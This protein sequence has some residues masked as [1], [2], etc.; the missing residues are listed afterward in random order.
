MKSDALGV[1]QAIPNHFSN[2]TFS[3]LEFK[4]IVT[5]QESSKI[6]SFFCATAEKRKTELYLLK[7]VVWLT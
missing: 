6:P 4:E 1:L 5:Q 3:V 2:G 7:G